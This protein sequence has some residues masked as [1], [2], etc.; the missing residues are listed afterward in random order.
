MPPPF[1]LLIQSCFLHLSHPEAF[2]ALSKPVMGLYYLPNSAA[3]DRKFTK[4]L[5]DTK[6]P[7]YY[8]TILVCT[9]LK[10]LYC[11]E[12]NRIEGNYRSWRGSN[13]VIGI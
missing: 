3:A 12:D 4:D 2:P 7:L 8:N 11:A 10:T 13:T 1:E 9:D 6:Q 5:L